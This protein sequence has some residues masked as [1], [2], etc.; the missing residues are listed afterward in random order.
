MN[1]LSQT[2]PISRRTF[3]GSGAAALLAASAVGCSSSSGPEGGSGGLRLTSRPATPTL[4]PDAGLSDLDLGGS[5][6]GVLYVPESYSGDRAVAL[7]VALHGAGGRGR[8]WQ[9][10]WARAEERSMVV[11]APDSRGSTWRFSY[12]G[13]DGDVAFLDR[14]LAHAFARCRVDPS[15]IALGGFSDGASY[16]LSLGLV[17]GDLF[18]HVVAY[19]LGY[20]VPPAEPVGRPPIFLSHGTQ[21]RILPYANARDVIVPALRDRGY[22]VDFV[23]FE[24]DHQVPAAI[25]EQALDWFLGAS[26]S[27]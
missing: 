23:S 11:L 12:D 5:R 16:A 8:A 24:G 2:R 17:N 27:S 15:R 10:Y 9:S 4:T 19:S 22:D 7:F 18:S 20:F 26:A 1:P 21:D 3:L 6:D 25:S 13:G 14:A